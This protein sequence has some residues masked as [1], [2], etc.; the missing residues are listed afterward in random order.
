[1]SMTTINPKQTSTPHLKRLDLSHNFDIEDDLQTLNISCGW[2]QLRKHPQPVIQGQD[3]ILEKVSV[4][5]STATI[6]ENKQKTNVWASPVPHA[7]GD[8]KVIPKWLRIPVPYFSNLYSCHYIFILAWSWSLGFQTF[9]ARFNYGCL[10]QLP[11]PHPP[12]L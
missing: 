5:L 12:L 8:W 1:M 10:F 11:T 2:Q 7:N 3:K 9:S 4:P 6:V